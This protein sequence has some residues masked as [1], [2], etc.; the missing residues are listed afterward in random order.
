M[1]S[2]GIVVLALFCKVVVEAVSFFVSV[3]NG[4]IFQKKNLFVTFVYLIKTW[5]CFLVNFFYLDQF[6]KI[7]H[8]FVLFYRILNPWNNVNK[9]FVDEFLRC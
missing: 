6:S 2:W 5:K 3:R 8:N 7:F 9:R 1:T 4:I